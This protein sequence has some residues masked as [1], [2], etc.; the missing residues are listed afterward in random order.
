MSIFYDKVRNMFYMHWTKLIA[1]DDGPLGLN[2]FWCIKT[3]SDKSCWFYTCFIDIRLY[4]MKD[5][6]IL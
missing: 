3:A 2:R 6:K 5:V 1:T 4:S